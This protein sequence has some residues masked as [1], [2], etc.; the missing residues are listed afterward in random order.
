MSSSMHAPQAVYVEDSA[1]G[2]GG[3]QW[4]GSAVGWEYGVG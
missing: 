2:G 1:V 4:G 3:V